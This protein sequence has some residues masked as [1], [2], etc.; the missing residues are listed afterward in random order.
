MRVSPIVFPD[1]EVLGRKLA[2]EIAAEIEEAARAGRTY[3]LGCPGGRSAAS[4][5]RALADEVAARGL[6]LGH[7]VVVMMDEYVEVT[8][9]GPRTPEYR[10]IDPD[11][12]HS[13][14]GFGRREI[15][16]PLNAAAGPGR[17]IGSERLWVPDPTDP[18]AYDRRIA[19]LGGIDLFLLASGAGD[20]HI[21]FNPAGSAVDSRTRV[22][23]LGEQTRT[24]NLATFPTFGGLADVPRYGVTVGIDTIRAQSRR[25]VMVA[26]GRDKG[27]AVQRLARAG[28]YEA[29][30]PATVFADCVRPRLYVDEAAM[31][32]SAALTSL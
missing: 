20:G 31:S 32:A 4:T 26:H 30:W 13:C 8:S 22:V 16:G 28:G 19:D 1:P 7:V 23:A 11:L 12:P 17:G 29:D 9:P 6:G 2:A 21:A 18:E 25:V 14:L 5:Y 24:D 27:R 10:V 15:V 3:V